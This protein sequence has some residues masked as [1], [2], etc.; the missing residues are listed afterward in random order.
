MLDPTQPKGRRYYWKS[1]YLPE[2]SDGLLEKFIEH[3]GRIRSPHSAM[4][5][6]PLGGKITTRSMD[7]SAVGNRDAEFVLNITSS[8]EDAADDDVNIGWA[9]DAWQDLRA[10][11]TG[12]TYINFLTEEEGTE[13][14]KDAFRGNLDRLVDIKTK[15]DPGNLFRMNK[16]IAPR[17]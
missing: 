3:A 2:V 16:N 10:F 9:R 5:L 17:G 14:V 1:E 12:G 4:I 11:S 13:R 8:W 7:H 6:F 15:W